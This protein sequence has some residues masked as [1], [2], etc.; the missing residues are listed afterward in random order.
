MDEK[1]ELID[2]AAEVDGPAVQSDL[3]E[4]AHLWQQI[5]TS[6]SV[7]KN[8]STNDADFLLFREAAGLDIPDGLATQRCRAGYIWVGTPD[9]RERDCAFM[10]ALE[11]NL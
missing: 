1:Q 8:S 9:E 10:A 5:L 2:A 11:E 6:E 3:T 7:Q 4:I